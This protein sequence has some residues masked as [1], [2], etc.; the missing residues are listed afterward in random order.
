MA[1]GAVN[2]L[3]QGVGI[4]GP[5]EGLVA[6]PAAIVPVNKIERPEE[7]P[8]APAAAADDDP[9]G[10]IA[11]WTTAAK[12]ERAT[13]AIRRLLDAG[14]PVAAGYSAGK[15]SSVM[16]ALL[17]NAAVEARNDGVELPPILI[18][19]ATTGVDNPAFQVV[20]Y[21][22]IAR[23]RAFAKAQDL[24]VRVD[25][26]EPALNDSWAVRIVS[27]RALPTFANSASRDCSITWKVIPQERQR[28]K[29][30]RELGGSGRPVVLLGTR[31]DESTVRGARMADRHETD[32]DVWSYEVRDKEGRVVRIED[33]LSPIAWWSQEDVWVYLRELVD[34]ARTSYTDAREVWEAYQDGG[35]STCAVVSDDRLKQSAKACGARF[36]CA[37]CAISRDKSLENM[38]EANERYAYMRNL[39]RLQRFLVD[40]QY[41]LRRRQWL[42]RSI[43]KDGFIAVAPDAYS[44]EM[45]RDLLR[46]AL[47]IDRDEEMAAR[48]AGVP[49]R[50]KLIDVRQLL[51]IDAI[52]ACQ[53]VFARPFEAI[54]IWRDV[55][56]DGNSHYPPDIVCAP[57]ERKIPAPRY[58]YV[59]R[60]WDDDPCAGAYTGLRDFVAEAAGVYD[61]Q[62]QAVERVRLNIARRRDAGEVV[63]RR[64]AARLMEEAGHDSGC[65]GAKVLGDGRVVMDMMGADMFDVDEQGAYDF[66][67]LEVMMS[68]ILDDDR[69]QSDPTSGYRHYVG[70]GLIAT[71]PQHIGTIDDMLR[72][73]SWKMRHGLIGMA[74]DDLMKR[75]ISGAERK[76][77][78]RAPA[79]QRTFGE[80][81]VDRLRSSRLEEHQ[82]SGPEGASLGEVK[83][84]E[85]SGPSL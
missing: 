78:A 85:D 45:L 14:R 55:C 3:D 26:V 12:A 25:V 20:A 47:T 39:N 37:L 8:P 54:R 15:D 49:T 66:L 58:L 40:T 52:W 41:D 76:G 43:D 27:G 6:A 44:P 36:G 30:L 18:T 21:S 51:A 11:D 42:G 59:G 33:R 7:G 10:P 1:T 70:L 9:I 63:S 84:A 72:R 57:T 67:E 65:V 82:A 71:T 50:F 68:N 73:T 61:R 34:G 46:Y 24:P 2:D 81:Y 56:V 77:G 38:L 19:H 13:K 35:N 48:R 53:G 62:D 5:F 17:L 16:V 69:Y 74:T 64:E 4:F 22:E 32:L 28:K 79:G 80:E 31:Y 75:S 83:E 29:V 60:E 23:I